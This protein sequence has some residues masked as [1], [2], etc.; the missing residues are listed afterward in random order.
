MSYASSFKFSDPIGPSSISGSHQGIHD[1]STTKNY[2]LG[3][4]VRA[5]DPVLGES[6]FI[7]A[8]GVA[9]TAVGNLIQLNGDYTTTRAAGGTIKGLC[10]VAMSASVAST[11]GWYCIKG[12]CLVLIA[13]DVTGDVPGYATATAGVWA[14]DIVAG[15]H[16][17]GSQLLNG[18]D[19][20]G[21]AIPNTTD[22]LAAHY[23]VARLFY[24]CVVKAV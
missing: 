21:S 11:Y 17:I 19:A 14:D 2:A 15:S 16:I 9:S 20:A 7:Y 10:G 4:R 3:T 12:S 22:T 1:F 5:I 8:T 24:P 6:E 18:T 13:A 23:T